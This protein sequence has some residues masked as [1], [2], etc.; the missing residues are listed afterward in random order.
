MQEIEMESKN[1]LTKKEYEAII[2]FFQLSEEQ[3]KT[4]INY[5]FETSDFKLKANGAALRIRKK[6]NDWVLTLKQPYQDG[7]IE[8]HD[9]LSE[10]EA[11]QAIEGKMI[12][13]PNV[14][15]QLNKLN[16]SINDLQYGGYLQTDRLEVTYKEGLVVID[17]SIYNGKSDYELEVEAVSKITSETIM[18]ELMEHLNIKKKAT[19]NKIERFYQTLTQ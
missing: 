6:D 16:I 19:P 7:L 10:I 17:Y 8:T 5:Y 3:A 9:S 18:Q 2:Q 11:M 15:K 13:K 12:D 1:L 14:N 4:Q